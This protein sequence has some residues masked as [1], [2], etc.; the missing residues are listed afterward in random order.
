M[1]SQRQMSGS[2]EARGLRPGSR[3]P[4]AGVQGS[5]VGVQGAKFYF[6]AQIFLHVPITMAT[7]LI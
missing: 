1:R 5:E 6:M 7:R 3:G 4:K 2:P